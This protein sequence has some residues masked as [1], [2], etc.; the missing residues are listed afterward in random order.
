MQPAKIVA[1]E[2]VTVET[3]VL[4]VTTVCDEIGDAHKRTLEFTEKVRTSREDR[5]AQAIAEALPELQAHEAK[6]ER[7]DLLKAQAKT[8]QRAI[9]IATREG[10]PAREK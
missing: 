4:G 2:L 5:T 6:I 8:E 10:K 7:V 3:F 9:E 1:R